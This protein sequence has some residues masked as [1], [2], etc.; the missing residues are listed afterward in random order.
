MT[1]GGVPEHLL[2]RGTD[3]RQKEH[4]LKL[5]HVITDVTQQVTAQATEFRGI[6]EARLQLDQEVNPLCVMSEFRSG[7]HSKVNKSK[8]ETFNI[9][10]FLFYIVI[11]SGVPP[12]QTER[13]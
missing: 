10:L 1:L 11:P 13:F 2:E 6:V 12:A 3:V 5:K 4:M 9:V 8:I 7:H